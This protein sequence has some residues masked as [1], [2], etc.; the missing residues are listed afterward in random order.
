MK[1]IYNKLVLIKTI[2]KRI[3]QITKLVGVIMH[4]DL[5]YLDVLHLVPKM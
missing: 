5:S 2:K 3:S 4:V 1:L